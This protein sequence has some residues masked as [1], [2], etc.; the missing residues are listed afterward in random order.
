[1]ATITPKRYA[2]VRET[3]LRA[4]KSFDQSEAYVLARERRDA[5]SREFHFLP[6]ELM[7]RA[8]TA[9]W[10]D[11]QAFSAKLLARGKLEAIVH[12]HIA[13]DDA[14]AATRSFAAGTGAAPAP[15]DALLRRRHVEIAVA[16]NI[17]DTAE[18]N[19]VN[20]AFIR[21]YVLADDSPLTRAASAVVAN[22]FS[23]PFYSELR[24]KQ[25]LGY[26][27]SSATANSQR[28]RYF[29]FTVQSSTHPPDEVRERA[30]AVIGSL[31]AALASVDDAKWKELVAG[32][33]SRLEEKPKTISEKAAL[34]YELAFTY[35]RDWN[36]REATLKALDTLTKDQAVAFLASALARESA[37]QR[38]VMLYSK[39]H[40]PAV[41]PKAAFTERGEWK[42]SRK[43]S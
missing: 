38:T 17:V 10:A 23:T 16:E 7:G 33:R 3:A 12:G 39:S 4:M 14:V 35:D 24:T 26:I 19:G 1:M 31:P 20:S 42:R 32:V 11:V 8:S 22:F 27:V 21:D 6:N 29:S 37:R 43:F 18:I 40:P 34:F 25:Q 13:P 30:E 2:E 28:Q 5:L 36:R 41:T 15:E 9:T